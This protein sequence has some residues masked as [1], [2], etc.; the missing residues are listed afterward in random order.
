MGKHKTAKAKNVLADVLEPKE[1]LEFLGAIGT[2]IKLLGDGTDE[3]RRSEEG[4]RL[5]EEAAAEVRQIPALRAQFAQFKGEK[6]PLA[7]TY[8]LVLVGDGKVLSLRYAITTL[9][10]ML[11]DQRVPQKFKGE[12]GA[13][14]AYA[15]R[16]AIQ[17]VM[18]AQTKEFEKNLELVP[19]LIE[20]FYVALDKGDVA[21]MER[22]VNRL[23]QPYFR[24]PLVEHHGCN[25]ASDLRPWFDSLQ[26]EVDAVKK[27]RQ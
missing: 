2:D 22:L 27:A 18:E 11:K 6:I 4:L 19:G 16:I 25:K 21:W 14:G 13:K 17:A 23:A 9:M 10:A 7:E 24:G 1:L 15:I 3:E 20:D 26:M 12:R 8:Y 5:R